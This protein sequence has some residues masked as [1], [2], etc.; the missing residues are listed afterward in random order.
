MKNVRFGFLLQL[1]LSLA[2]LVTTVWLV[3]PWPYRSIP[4]ASFFPTLTVTPTFRQPTSTTIPTA[5]AVTPTATA[6]PVVH[7]VQPGEVLGV[8]AKLYGVTAESI[9][10]A[11]GIKDANLLQRGEKLLIPNPVQTPRVTAIQHDTTPTPTAPSAYR[12]A[13]PVPLSPGEG[14][15]FEGRDAS[16]VL[17]WASTTT[18]NESE[19]FEVRFW[20]GDREM[21]SSERFHTSTST[22]TVPGTLYPAAGNNQCYWTVQV[23]YHARRDIALSPASSLRSLVWR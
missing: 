16:V 19:L 3:W 6:V 2:L 4:E 9:M 8:I 7:V 12:D 15:V 21:H 11:N 22:W 23:V 5:T 20:C 10:E 18:L 17:A 1:L 14:E 13:A